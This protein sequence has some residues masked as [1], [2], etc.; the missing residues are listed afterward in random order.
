M[1][2]TFSSAVTELVAIGTTAVVTHQNE[3]EVVAV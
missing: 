2:S 1:S 3:F